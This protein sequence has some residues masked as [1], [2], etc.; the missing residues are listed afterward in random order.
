MKF[1]FL[2]FS[3]IPLQTA[4][5]LRVCS[6]N[7]P[8]L[9]QC[10]K[11]AVEHIRPRLASGY[12][13]ETFSVPSLEPLKLDNLKINRGNDLNAVFSNLL[14]SGPSKFQI[15]KLKWVKLRISR[16]FRLYYKFYFHRASVGDTLKVDF[17]ISLPKLEYKGKYS[18]KMR[19]LL[20]DISGRGDMTGTL[21][22]TKARI[23]IRGNKYQK[24]GQTYLKF[25]KF[26]VKA[27][28]ADGTFDLQNLFNGD[29][30][31]GQVGNQFINE[32]S[33]L[34]LDEILPG[35]EKTLADTFTDIANQ[36]LTESTF[37][38]LFP[39]T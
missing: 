15:E 12:F 8:N 26:N 16:A 11:N 38:E 4:P 36:I 6:R 31:L 10:I 34:F 22:N 37:D 13:D 14:I 28:V 20:L 32:N 29:P 21:V 7:D 25:E 35:L 19:I 33:R 27:Q 17:I 39:D 3:L 23:K 24:N 30:V 18:L 9:S 2:Y 1:N 5:S